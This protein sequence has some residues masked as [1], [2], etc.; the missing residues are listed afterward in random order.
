MHI[1]CTDLILSVISPLHMRVV[2]SGVQVPS[3]VTPSDVQ[4]AFI[5][6]AG[7][8]PGAHMKNISAPPNVLWYGSMEPFRGAVGILQST[9]SDVNRKLKV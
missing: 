7:T 8:N 4:F 3:T 5:L 6:P 9:V 2:G 1:N